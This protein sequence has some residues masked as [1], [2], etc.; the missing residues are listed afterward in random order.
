MVDLINVGVNRMGGYCA[1]AGHAAARDRVSRSQTSRQPSRGDPGEP[2]GQAAD[3]KAD[4]GFR[5]HLPGKAGATS[6]TAAIEAVKL[7]TTIQLSLAGENTTGVVGEQESF[8]QGDARQGRK[9]LEPLLAK[10]NPARR[11]T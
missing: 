9:Y 8:V 2:S 6:S 1:R 3:D 4:D 7:P 10:L 11:P 5:H